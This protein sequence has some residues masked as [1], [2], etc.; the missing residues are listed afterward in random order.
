MPRIDL[1]PDAACLYNALDPYHVTFDN[2]PLENIL[3][4][5][6]LINDVVDIDHDILTSAK[7]STPDLATRIDS[8]LEL[9]G[10]LKT[11]AMD[12][13]LHSIESHT[14]TQDQSVFLLITDE[15]VRMTE[16]ERDKLILI[17][18]EAT[19]ISLSFESAGTISGTPVDF[20]NGTVVFADS[21]STSWRWESGIGLGKIYLDLNFPLESAHVHFYD[22]APLNPLGDFLTYYTTQDFADDSLRVFVNGVRLSLD[23]VYCPVAT[24][25]EISGWVL[26]KIDTIDA[27]NKKFVLMTPLTAYDLITVDFDRPY[28]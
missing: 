15:F 19:N 16:R 5:Q 2:K 1:I 22:Q 23:E 10:H 18:D 9:D 14:D 24:A 13:A 8:S 20:S 28:L 17:A 3:A 26:N 6:K 12:L 7:G 27:I 21:V 11:S 4:R 25:T